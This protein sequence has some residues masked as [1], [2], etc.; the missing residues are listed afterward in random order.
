LPNYTFGD[1]SNS[2]RIVIDFIHRE[3]ITSHVMISAGAVFYLYE[4]G[5]LKSGW[6]QLSS[7]E[8]CDVNKVNEIGI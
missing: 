1:I 5:T 6:F 7:K 2:I 3:R 4:S 8:M